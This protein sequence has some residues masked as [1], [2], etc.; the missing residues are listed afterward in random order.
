MFLECMTYRY[1]GHSLSD[2]GSAYRSS[3]EVLAWKEK[4]CLDRFINEIR[5]TN[6]ISEEEICEI[7][8]AVAAMVEEATMRAAHAPEPDPTTLHEGLFAPAVQVSYPAPPFP[9]FDATLRA[10]SP[11]ARPLLRHY[12]KKWKSTPG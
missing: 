10:N 3:E 8:G 7:K 5:Q 11:I 12:K 1:Y 4:D 2:D 6:V 9:L